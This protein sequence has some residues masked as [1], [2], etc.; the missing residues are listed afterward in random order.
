[1]PR[2]FSGATT[3]GRSQHEHGLAGMTPFDPARRD[4]GRVH[5][6]LVRER[7][8]HGAQ[9]GGV[10]GGRAAGA[11][12]EEEDGPAARPDALDGLDGAGNRGGSTDAVRVVRVKERAVDVE[13][14]RLDTG[15]GSHAARLRRARSRSPGRSITTSSRDRSTSPSTSERSGCRSWRGRASPGGRDDRLDLLL[16][17]H[18]P[19][20]QLLVA[21]GVAVARAGCLEPD[22][23]LFAGELFGSRRG[24]HPGL[25]VGIDL[26][27][28]RPVLAQHVADHLV[29]E[30]RPAL[31]A[32]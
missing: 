32:R 3:P 9:V 30:P 13:D 22:S 23:V 31:A 5:E 11:V 24:Q 25:Q 6:L 10:V 4:D 27:G 17:Q 26:T 16:R 20:E 19:Q 18:H 1:M 2:S 8:A 14:D 7:E 29:R 21:D 12:G 15:E 28:R